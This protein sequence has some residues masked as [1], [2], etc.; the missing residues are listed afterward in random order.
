LQT[1]WNEA[2]I[3]AAPPVQLTEVAMD[4]VNDA[5]ERVMVVLRRRTG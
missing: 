3:L 2:A 4:E 1:C 5:I